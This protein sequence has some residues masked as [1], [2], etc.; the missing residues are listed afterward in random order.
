MQLSDKNNSAYFKKLTLA[1]KYLLLYLDALLF[2]VFLQSLPYIIFLCLYTSLIFSIK[3]SFKNYVHSGEGEGVGGVLK[4]W[5]KTNKGRGSSLSLCLL[6]EKNCL[7]FQTTNR[8]L[9]FFLTC[10][11]VAKNISVLALSPAYKG[12]FFLLKRRRHS[13]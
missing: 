13:F 9:S 3:K 4:E 7:I 5:T 11:A 2:H 8:V 10:S 6:C 12:G 1:I